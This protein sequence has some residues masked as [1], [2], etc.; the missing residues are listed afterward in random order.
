MGSDCTGDILQYNYLTISNCIDS[1]GTCII[2][3]IET[4]ETLI[5]IL[6]KHLIYSSST[7]E[8]I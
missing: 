7:V 1:F 2:I 3:D 8:M 5:L 6:D 4:G